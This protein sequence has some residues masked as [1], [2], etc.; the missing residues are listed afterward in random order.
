MKADM[1]PSIE[2]GILKREKIRFRLKGDFV[3]TGG[4]DARES[5]RM[6]PGTYDASVK[7]GTIRITGGGR[8][9]QAGKPQHLLV[10]GINRIDR[11]FVAEQPEVL[12]NLQTRTGTVS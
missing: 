1:A 10:A 11:S 9:I 7:D 2:V 5:S 3:W 12:Q 8:S 4:G 6:K